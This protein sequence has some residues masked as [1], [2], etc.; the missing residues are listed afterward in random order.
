MEQCKHALESY[1]K[2]E[3]LKNADSLVYVCMYVYI[4]VCYM[5]LCMYM[6][7]HK[8]TSEDVYLRAMY[9]RARVVY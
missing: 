1:I 7:I 2:G 3:H 4:Y 9:T 6:C 8:R 5:Y